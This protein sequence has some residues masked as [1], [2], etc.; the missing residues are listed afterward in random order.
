MKIKNFLKKRQEGE[1]TYVKPYVR[2]SRGYNRNTREAAFWRLVSIMLILSAVSFGTYKF[3]IAGGWL[4]LTIAGVTVVAIYSIIN[5]KRWKRNILWLKV[6]KL[7]QVERDQADEIH[8]RSRLQEL[9]TKK[10]R[11]KR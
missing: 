3:F 10:Q 8:I 5:W 9:E 11:R 4:I 7:E 6:K 1:Y 2:R